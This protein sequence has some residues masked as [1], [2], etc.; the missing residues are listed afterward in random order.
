MK[1]LSIVLQLMI[2]ILPSC[3]KLPIYRALFGYEIGRG[4]RIG[5]SPI[6]GVRR[7][8]IGDGTRIG[9]FNLFYRVDQ[10]VIGRQV[11]VGF[12]NGFRGGKSIR[13]GDYCSILRMNT[14]NAII[15]GDF[16]SHSIEPTLEIGAGAVITTGHWLDFSAGIRMGD[17]VILG[18]RN[19]SLWT[20]NRQIGRPISLAS[21][22]YL[23]SEVRLA[24]GVAVAP[25]CV[26]ALGSVLSG[27][28]DAPR[29]LI[30]G[31]P[32]QVVRSLSERD[33]FLVTRKTRRDIPDE[34]ELE[35]LPEDL[36]VVA[37]RNNRIAVGAGRIGD[38]M[39]EGVLRDPL[40]TPAAS[41]PFGEAV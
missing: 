27:R 29:S 3:L 26:V 15:D 30:G 12:L 11:R 22:T 32:A 33:M 31:N 6:V 39:S 18:G 35:C 1:H 40:A 8:R 28:F 36:H 25:F 21:H 2:A 34:F 19:S 16:I 24:P 7:L 4:V 20:H 37:C 38:R 41:Q 9:W 23:G 10:V 5:F 13:I 17:H 14:V